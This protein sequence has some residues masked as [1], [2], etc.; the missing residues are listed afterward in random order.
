MTHTTRYAE[1]TDFIKE[2]LP[3]G[4]SIYVVTDT[5][6]IHVPIVFKSR[7][8]S[9]YLENVL[10]F[11]NSARVQTFSDCFHT[12]MNHLFLDGCAAHQS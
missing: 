9:M 10:L 2:Y 6:G 7:K 1:H 8:L 11:S 12:K 5:H 4:I 3:I